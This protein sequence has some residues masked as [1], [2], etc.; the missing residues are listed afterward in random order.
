MF[1]R[2]GNFLTSFL[3][4]SIISQFLIFNCVAQ[5]IELEEEGPPVEVNECWIQFQPSCSNYTPFPQDPGDGNRCQNQCVPGYWQ[6]EEIRVCSSYTR[7]YVKNQSVNAVMEAPPGIVGNT[8]L[9]FNSTGWFKDCALQY[10]CECPWNKQAGH[11]A[12]TVCSQAN[13]PPL[14]V[15]PVQLE[16][17]DYSSPT[18][19]Q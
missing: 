16:F 5:V 6:G 3:W 7:S 10:V 1:H 19:N 14:G 17:V 4:V 15:V 11:P 9:D 12:P 13:V 8:Q 2:I 18:C